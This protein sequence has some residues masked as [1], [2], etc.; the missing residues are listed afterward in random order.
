MSSYV[1]WLTTVFILV[2]LGMSTVFMGLIKNDTGLIIGGGFITTFGA[3]GIGLVQSSER[4][5]N[6]DKR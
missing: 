2:I 4:N 3:I 6:R 1:L 5:K